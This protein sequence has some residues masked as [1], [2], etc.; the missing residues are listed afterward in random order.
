M[1]V[2]YVALGYA[3]RPLQAAG[4]SWNGVSL[5]W[6]ENL[7][8]A[9]WIWW[10][11][12]AL[13][14][15]PYPLLADR[16]VEAIPHP[17]DPRLIG[18]LAAGCAVV[19]CAWRERTTQPLFA[20]G[21]G[22]LLIA[23]GPVSNVIPLLNPM[24]DRYLYGLAPG[25]A[26]VATRFFTGA[27]ARRDLLAAV[28]VLWIVL[29]QLQLGRWRDDASLWTATARLEPRSARAHVG[30][31]LMAKQ[32]GDRA[33]ARAHFQQAEALNPQEV[34]AR[35][36]LAIL[37]GEE[38]DLASAEKQLRAATQRRPEKSEA[39]VNLAVALELQGKR[40]EARQASE[41]ARALDLL[42]P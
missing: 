1:V 36:N 17:W 3:G 30:L 18:C 22:W 20:L 21:L 41:K 42:G 31:G 12:V 6:P 25:F 19:W 37:D 32:Q 34:S 9:P 4:T 29:L 2:G 13:F 28:C 27:P 39:W 10:R 24:A 26:L 33:A 35:I 8:T 15:V 5:R 16:V 38:G 11:Y 7:W 23:F 14:V 40:E